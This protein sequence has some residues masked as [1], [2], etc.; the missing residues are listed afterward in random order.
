MGVF[1]NGFNP[2]N[3]HYILNKRKTSLNNKKIFVLV[4]GWYQKVTYV[5]APEIETTKI[6]ICFRDRL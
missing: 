3:T 4:K 6:Q 5:T 2:R 1:I